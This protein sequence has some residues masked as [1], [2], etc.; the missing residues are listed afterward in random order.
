MEGETHEYVDVLCCHFCSTIQVIT[1]TA[2]ACTYRTF[3]PLFRNKASPTHTN[4]HMQECLG[5]S[6]RP[7]A[8]GNWSGPLDCESQETIHSQC[9]L[10][11]GERLEGRVLEKGRM[12]RA[13]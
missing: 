5:V 9:L 10:Q 6:R 8:M 1:K 2:L 4:I 7:D 3:C 12:V 11:A 13:R